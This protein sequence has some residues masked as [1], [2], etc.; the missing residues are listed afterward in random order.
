MRSV[1]RQSRCFAPHLG[2]FGF[3]SRVGLL[4]LSVVPVALAGD[5]RAGG[6]RL[7]A[8]SRSVAAVAATEA[9]AI[10][11][12]GDLT[13]AAWA[14]APIIGDFVQRDPNEGKAPSFRTEARVVY[15]HAALFVAVRA[16]DPDPSKIVGLLTRRDTDSPSD[17]VGIVV[18]SYHDRRT[19]YEFDVNAAGV[20]ADKYR[21]NDTNEDSSWD[22]VWDVRVSRDE[23]GWTAQFR[24][25]FSQLRFDP[26]RAD[27]FGFAVVRR[28]GRLN[29]TSTW[30]LLPR[31][32]P[33]YVSSLGELTGLNL[34]GGRKRLEV[35]PYMVGQVE[36]QTVQAGNPFVRAKDASSS[37]GADAKF[38]VTPGLTLTA[39]LNPDFGQVEADPA[40][41]NLSAFETYF[42]ERRPFF[43]EGSGIFRFDIDCNDGQ[44]RG[45]FYS[46][47]IG[48]TPRG[49]PVVPDGG[50]SSIP[51]QTTILG[52]AKLTG[53]VGKFSVGGLN[54]ITSDER[55]NVFDG[56][57]TSRALVE[58]LTSYS[59]GR[60]TREFA[61]QS[62]LG[63]M[64]TATNRRLSSELSFLP[65]DAYT[66]G[67]DWDWRLGRKGA[68]SLSGYVA[69]STVRGSTEAIAELQQS[70]VHAYQRP[71]AGHVTLDTSRTSLNGMSA[72]ASIS[73]L[74]G[75]RVR[76]NSSSW[77]KT[78]GFDINDLG[79]LQR[80]DET[81]F[82]NWFQVRTD[83][84]SKHFRNKRLNFNQWAVFNFD[85]DRLAL[86]GNVNGNVRTQGN[87]QV[88]AGVNLEAEAF[89]DRLT[90]GGPGGR[91]TQWVFFWHSFQS[92]DRKPVQYIHSVQGGRDRHDSARFGFNPAIR[93]RPSS[94]LSV[95]VGLSLSRNLDDSQ[96]VENVTESAPHG[97]GGA[98]APG[99]SLA[100]T[101]YVFGRLD[102][103]TVAATLRVNYTL[104]PRLSIQLYG[105]PFVSAGGYDGFKELV[106]GRAAAYEDRYAPYPYAGDPNFNYKSFRTTN[107]LRWEYRPGSTL[108]VV[109]QQGREEV[110]DAG[111]FR[112]GRDFGDVFRAAGHNVFLVKMAH[113]LNF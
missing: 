101:H 56:A 76:F 68:Y 74:A 13:D 10:R 80:A 78:P 34:Q 48:R 81:G 26:N 44:C 103:T 111:R 30:P 89:D 28:V 40:V 31:S 39:T 72:Q 6:A 22:A 24:I 37:F 43:V 97:P 29:E 62:S 55:A 46:R 67:T 35:V 49:T 21:F 71:D 47:R 64:M 52:A 109:W 12:D 70:M 1:K 108:F 73:R 27:T 3:F 83:K 15:D 32:A 95:A 11:L 58:P 20:K 79:F 53:R 45:L 92:D 57:S 105:A 36:T 51:P 110:T 100:T 59:V 14:S 94:A 7:P 65:S 99:S 69:A 38:A 50:F 102:Q 5:G 18:D 88:G 8:G 66:G 19:A 112:F 90:R 33:G 86:G 4:F 61:N 98:A 113:W 106:D 93:V 23:Q 82:A 42:D 87:H 107:V 17:W 75:D 41:V 60:A 63:F 104:T 9:T 77:M 16:Y 85:G 2:G 25:P 91:T 54:A 96:W 84:P